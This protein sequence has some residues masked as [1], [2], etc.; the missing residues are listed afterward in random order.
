MM[1][2]K[3]GFLLSL[4]LPA[5]D[6]LPVF[7]S[8]MKFVQELA[9]NL[10]AEAEDSAEAAAS[11]ADPSMH[12]FTSRLDHFDRQNT[13]TWQQRSFQNATFFNGSGPVFL[14][15][16][17]EGPPLDATVLTNSV[18]CNDMV[19]LAPKVGALML[20]VEHRYYGFSM[21]AADDKFGALTWRK[22][23][24][25]LSSQQALADLA[26]F[27]LQIS[28][29]YSLDPARNK[30]VSFGGSYPGMMAGFFRLKYPH[31]VHAAVSSS[32]PWLAKV[33]MQEYQDIVGDSL[34]IE[35]IGGSD[36]CKAVVVD[37][38]AAIGDAI[39]TA[40]GRDA[41]AAQFNFCDAGQGAL[42]SEAVAGQWAGSGVIAVPSQ[43]NDP[44]CASDDEGD[45]SVCDIGRICAVL[46]D[47]AYAGDDVAALA[48]VSALQRSGQCIP[49]WS[50]EAVRAAE[51]QLVRSAAA[52][53]RPGLLPAGALPGGLRPRKYGLHSGRSRKS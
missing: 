38:H 13:A 15:V 22:S 33:D 34:A 6:A 47:D 11:E 43:E 32:S 46:T 5:G 9:Q 44:G 3:L 24:Q 21:P 12:W 30:W 23:L 29:N 27:H 4:L 26:E 40:E 28:Q 25:W 7:T 48:A 50:T 8:G 52:L 19:E 36:A 18:H 51:E 16:G 2:G 45:Q 49:G 37:G 17:G 41:L 39:Q 20:A 42:D 1:K 14:C 35:S 10:Q 31:L 53:Q